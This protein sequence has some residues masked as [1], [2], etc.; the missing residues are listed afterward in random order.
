MGRAQPH[1][2]A[3]HGTP[4]TNCSLQAGSMKALRHLAGI[5]RHVSALLSGQL[6][7]CHGLR[8]LDSRDISTALLACC[9]RCEPA[10]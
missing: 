7:K 5:L 4:L 6:G 1:N 10:A 8:L 9:C 2:K 3:A